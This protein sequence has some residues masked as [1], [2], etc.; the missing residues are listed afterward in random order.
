M[1]QIKAASDDIAKILK[2]IDEIAFQTNI[3][4]LNAA[5]EAARAGEAGAGF[6]VVA[7]EVRALAK[8]SAVAARET[9][10]K[11]DDC[12]QKSRQ[13]VEISAGVAAN[14]ETIQQQ[15]R[16]LDGLVANIA[17]ASDEQST[18]LGQ[19]NSSVQKLDHVVE[20]TAASAEESAAVASELGERV[21]HS[22]AIIQ[23]LLTRGS[24]SRRT[25]RTGL[26]ETRLPGGR[27]TG[28]PT[29][30]GPARLAAERPVPAAVAAPRIRPP[31]VH[32]SLPAD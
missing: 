12:A 21:Q 7:G 13:G 28:D 5:V 30:V 6:S 1:E 14:F 19:L 18:G 31:A 2:T 29:P 25:D 9:A 8:R 16:R 22:T 26:P 15:I 4:A 27:R 11:I 23:A 17:S 10:A 32:R 3:L 24:G 20:R